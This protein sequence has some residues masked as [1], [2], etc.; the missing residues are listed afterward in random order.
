MSEVVD[1]FD[2]QGYDMQSRYHT[3]YALLVSCVLVLGIVLGVREQTDAS[4]PV[5]P[6]HHVPVAPSP[7]PTV[8][9]CRPLIEP[10]QLAVHQCLPSSG[11]QQRGVMSVPPQD[12]PPAGI[13]PRS[14]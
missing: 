11:D 14:K 12:T 13:N 10:E 1:A 7:T 6:S 3:F 9:S 4:R 5:L 8:I 2:R